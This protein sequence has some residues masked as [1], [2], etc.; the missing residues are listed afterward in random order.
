MRGRKNPINNQAPPNLPPCK[1]CGEQGTGFHYGVT[2]C[3]ACKV[4]FDCVHHP[5]ATHT[6]LHANRTLQLI[7]KMIDTSRL[8]TGA[9]AT[10]IQP[11]HNRTL[12]LQHFFF[13]PFSTIPILFSPVHYYP[14]FV[15]ALS[16]LCIFCFRTFSTIPI[17]FSPV[18]YYH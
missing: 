1:I 13:R 3:G 11:V 17:L 6:E 15:F 5:L 9:P 16:L 18:L 14:Y 8:N 7:K 10:R 12:R 2:A 4:S